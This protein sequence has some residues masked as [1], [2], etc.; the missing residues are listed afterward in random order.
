[1][2]NKVLV[3]GAV[4]IDIF[5]ASKE[6]ILAG[7]SNPAAINLAVGGVGGNIVINLTNLGS[8]VTFLTVFGE[9]T[10]GKIAQDRFRSI[11]TNITHAK[12]VENIPSSV[13]LAVMDNDNDLYVGLNDMALINYLDIPF[14]KERHKLIS[15][16]DTI[17]I[18]N[19]LSLEVLTYIVD[20]YQDKTIIID[21]VSAHKVGKLS[22]LLDKITIL[23]VNELELETLSQEKTKETQINDLL[24]RGLHKVIVTNK[25]QEII[26]KSLTETIKELPLQCNDI[27]NASG[28]G[29]AFISGYIYGLINHKKSPIKYAKKLAFL[30][31]QVNESTTRK[32]NIDD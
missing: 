3:I 10:F 7:D 19:N 6:K 11:G 26:E 8:D 20:T 18:D 22:G 24:S 5:A 32:V 16:F 2:L 28:A 25:D 15:A 21:A 17:V 27:V 14:I 23:K 29:D 13:Y 4:N 9:D 1:M 30:T 12:T 31:L